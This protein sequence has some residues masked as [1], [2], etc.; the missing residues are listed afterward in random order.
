MGD[1]LAAASDRDGFSRLDP[2]EQLAELVFRFESAN[3][4]RVDPSG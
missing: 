1:D 3:F 4:P 2:I